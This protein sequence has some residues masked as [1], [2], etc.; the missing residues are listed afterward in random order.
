MKPIIL[1]VIFF[2]QLT[3]VG[4]S[5]TNN[6]GKTSS[7]NIVNAVNGS[8]A[9]VTDFEP[10]GP[11]TNLA[12]S[13]QYF[14]TANQI[15]YGAV[16]ESGSYAG[17]VPISLFQTTD[18]ATALWQG[19]IHL[20]P[21]SIQT[22]YLS[23]DTSSVDT[24]LLSDNIPFYSSSDSVSGLRFINLIWGSQP[25]SINLVGNAPSEVEFDNI[26]YQEISG[27]KQYAANIASPGAL[28]FEIR[29]RN[30]DSLLTTFQ[31]SSTLF[32]N[33]TIVLMGSERNILPEPIQVLAI[34]N[35]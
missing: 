21:G 11:K 19:S 10:I 26:G 32:K 14:A 35:F 25:V 1:L 3:W 15:S 20:I 28:N 24:L 30:S 27:F 22:L 29:D 2:M 23:G 13:L 4:C 16:W 34:N 6:W 5:K 17:E 8:S 31:W 12:T 33:N 9:I 7:L 18:S